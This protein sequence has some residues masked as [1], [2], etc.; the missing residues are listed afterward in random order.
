MA[1]FGSDLQ[2]KL[3]KQKYFLVSGPLGCLLPS[4]WPLTI[5]PG[6]SAFQ[7]NLWGIPVAILLIL[8]GS[9][10]HPLFPALV[11]PSSH[12]FVSFL[13]VLEPE[14]VV[15]APLPISQGSEG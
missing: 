15:L 6:A 8:K 5:C 1:V 7:C 4:S 9:P 10:V 11:P 13:R 2:E 3:G 14:D 12:D